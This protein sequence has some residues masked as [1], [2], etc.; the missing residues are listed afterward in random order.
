MRRVLMILLAA[1]CLLPAQAAAQEVECFLN[2]EGTLIRLVCQWQAYGQYDCW[3]E[4]V[5]GEIDTH[6][7]G[8]AMMPDGRLVGLDSWNGRL[9]TIDTETAATTPL[10]DLDVVGLEI[11]ADPFGSIFMSGDTELYRVDL[12]TGHASLVGDTGFE[13]DRLGSLGFDLYATTYW[14]PSYPNGAFMRIDPLTAQPVVI[15]DSNLGLSALSSNWWQLW[16]A[17]GW[18]GPAAHFELVVVDPAGV[19]VASLWPAEP[20]VLWLT[21]V[22]VRGPLPQAPRI[23]LLTRPLLGLL[24]LLLAAAGV[25]AIRRLVA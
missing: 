5:V 10:V 24:A 9:V 2:F 14:M 6:I 16:G 8:T 11:A 15:R 23:P 25:V 12:A 21:D 19:S 20:G 17:I 18:G 22:E 1:G 13:I 3:Q 7:E 4:S